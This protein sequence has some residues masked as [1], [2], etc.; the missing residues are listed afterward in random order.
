MHLCLLTFIGEAMGYFRGRAMFFVPIPYALHSDWPI[1]GAK[2]I[3]LNS[4]KICIYSKLIPKI[5][6]LEKFSPDSKVAK[7]IFSFKMFQCY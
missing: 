5:E 1:L 7:F 2:Y 6:T 4:S 3:L